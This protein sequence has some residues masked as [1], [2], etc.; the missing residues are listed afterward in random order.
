ML[1]ILFTLILIPS[2]LSQVKYSVFYSIFRP[3]NG[4]SNRDMLGIMSLAEYDQV[5]WT[6]INDRFD[7]LISNMDM[8]ENP[9]LRIHLNDIITS[10]PLKVFLSQ[11]GEVVK[12]ICNLQL[13]LMLNGSNQLYHASLSVSNGISAC[14][15]RPLSV[16]ISQSQQV[17]GPRLTKPVL[18]QDGQDSTQSLLGK[19]W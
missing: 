5:E 16:K 14:E 18:A 7:S 17:K 15:M 6:D 10:M 13:N 11:K 9:L 8:S 1:H 19:Y 2:I 4:E 3:G 12:S